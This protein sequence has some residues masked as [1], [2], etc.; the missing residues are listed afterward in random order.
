MEMYCGLHFQFR[1]AD[2]HSWNTLY[3]LLELTNIH[4]ASVGRRQ[5]IWQEGEDKTETV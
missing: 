2:Y 4:Q 5:N 1:R 3:F